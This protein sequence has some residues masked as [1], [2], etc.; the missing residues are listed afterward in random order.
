MDYELNEKGYLADQ[1]SWTEDIA[2]DLASKDGLELTQEHWDLINFLRD[3][4][5]NN[6]GNTPNTRNIQKGMAK[7]WGVKKID[8]KKLYELFPHDPSKQG[9]KI[10]G[11]PESKRKGGY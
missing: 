6:A 1:A 2:K 9:G 11:L 8:S 3:E 7:I 5:F 4:F 10:A